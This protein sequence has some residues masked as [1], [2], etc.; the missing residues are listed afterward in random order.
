MDP[1]RSVRGNLT[2]IERFVGGDQSSVAS[3][4]RYDVAGN[5]TTS[6]DP[7]KAETK[8]E[9][10]EPTFAFPTRVEDPLHHFS[11]A[12]FDHD[13]GQRIEQTDPNG[14]TTDFRI[15]RPPGSPDRRRGRVQRRRRQDPDPIRVS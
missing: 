11:S 7:L 5:V 9:Y 12:L 6:T 10:A 14:V 8:I 13:T 4:Y 2:R 1:Q 3:E 15:R